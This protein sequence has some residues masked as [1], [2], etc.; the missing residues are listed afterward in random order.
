M[1][2]VRTWVDKAFPESFEEI[3]LDDDDELADE[4]GGDALTDD[5]DDNLMFF[6]YMFSHVFILYLFYALHNMSF[7]SDLHLPV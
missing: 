4:Y 3:L 5:E 1:H 6:I 2:S 7:F